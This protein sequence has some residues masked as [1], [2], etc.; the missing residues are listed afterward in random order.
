M[1]NEHRTPAVGE[2]EPGE[3]PGD[4]A[5]SR[6]GD[7]DPAGDCSS[8]KDRLTEG[9]DDRV[10]GRRRQPLAGNKPLRK[11]KRP[12]R[13]LVEP[14]ESEELPEVIHDG[15]SVRRRSWRRR[16]APPFVPRDYLV[17]Q[18]WGER[19]QDHVRYL[20]ADHL[21]ALLGDHTAL[22]K[23]MKEAGLP[24]RTRR[25]L[26]LGE[27]RVILRAYFFVTGCR[28]IRRGRKAR[29]CGA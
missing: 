15:H 6:R 16:K 14:D 1:G 8:G 22:P 23:A 3:H 13:V 12:A 18:H 17:E 11:Q 7:R 4:P 24:G 2:P 5:A 29:G 28:A 19:D 26:S 21:R 27:C 9:L 25:W 10:G 20:H